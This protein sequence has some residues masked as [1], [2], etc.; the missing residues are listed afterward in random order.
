MDGEEG[1]GGEKKR[2]LSLLG[3]ENSPPI[4][5]Q[6]STKRGH[7]S[8]TL[9]RSQGNRRQLELYHLV[10]PGSMNA[11]ASSLGLG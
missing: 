5:S 2:I 7:F 11:V 3:G 8:G 4:H 9:S 6:L 10:S 1:G